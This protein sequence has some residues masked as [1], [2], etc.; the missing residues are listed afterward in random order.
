MR[1]STDFSLKIGMHSAKVILLR[2]WQFRVDNALKY[3]IVLC[4]FWLSVF[5]TS[6]MT[7]LVLSSSRFVVVIYM[8][9]L[10]G[11]EFNKKRRTSSGN[12][13]EWHLIL[14]LVSLSPPPFLRIF[15]CYS[16]NW[17][18]PL[19]LTKVLFWPP[20]LRQKCWITYQ[21][22]NSTVRAT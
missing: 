15:L 2:F 11:I 19:L 13:V 12:W 22:V 20:T 5:I 4:L 7:C 8:W 9:K 21:T 14:F 18:A 16:T 10:A 17:T 1:Q 6:A 3:G